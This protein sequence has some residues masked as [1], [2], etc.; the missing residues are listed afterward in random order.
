MPTYRVKR[1]LSHNNKPYSVNSVIE[2]EEEEA[3]ALVESGTVE[4]SDEP[5]STTPPQPLV[6]K[7]GLDLPG[8]EQFK[9]TNSEE[10]QTNRTSLVN[11]NVAIPEDLMAL[12]NIKETTAEA[13]VSNRPYASVEEVR[14]KANLKLSEEKWN[15]LKA[16]ITVQP[17]EGPAVQ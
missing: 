14:T 6:T 17:T 7:T 8:G 5:V 9:S 12:P 10:L 13:I 15:Q 2:M 4:P 1:P 16:L 3:I 11:I